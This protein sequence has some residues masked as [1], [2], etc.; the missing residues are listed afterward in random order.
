MVNHTHLKRAR[1]PIPPL[2]HIYCLEA[3]FLSTY[4]II[5]HFEGFVKGFFEF[6]RISTKSTTDW[7]FRITV[8]T[9]SRTLR[10]FR[11]LLQNS[12]GC[13]IIILEFRISAQVDPN[14]TAKHG[15]HVKYADIISAFFAE[16]RR[17]LQRDA[18]T[19]R[20]RFC[21]AKPSSV[22]PKGTKGEQL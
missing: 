4:N 22:E 3:S 17:I 8:C 7:H 9:I 1:L 14:S 2:S 13:D 21:F 16:R 12:L 11:K 20:S 5:P 19:P 10:N 6:F 15:F 18:A